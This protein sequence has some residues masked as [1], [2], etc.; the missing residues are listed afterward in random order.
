[1]HGVDFDGC[2]FYYKYKTIGDL[3][4]KNS[5]FL[6]K[7][8]RSGSI[9]FS[10]SARHNVAN[11][12]LN[13]LLYL[14]EGFSSLDF[15]E[16]VKKKYKLTLDQFLF[17]DLFHFKGKEGETWEFIQKIKSNINK[18]VGRYSKV[19]VKKI[20]LSQKVDEAQH[21]ATKIVGKINKKYRLKLDVFST[22][23]FDKMS[24]KRLKQDRDAQ[25]IP[26]TYIAAQ[27]FALRYPNEEVVLNLYDDKLKILHAI[28]DF[29]NPEINH[30]IDLIPKNVT[31]QLWLRKINKEKTLLSS[32]KG[33]GQVDR[34]WKNTV[35]NKEGGESKLKHQY[36]QF[37]YAI[38]CRDELIVWFENFISSE[39]IANGIKSFIIG[40]FYKIFR[41][42][43]DVYNEMLAN[44]NNSS[45][46]VLKSSLLIKVCEYHLEALKAVTQ[47]APAGQSFISRK[48][49]LPL[50]FKQRSWWKSDSTAT[51][52]TLKFK[53]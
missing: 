7:T 14:Q 39:K 31:I 38:K 46:N 10:F 27:R 12:V 43:E 6:G 34:D 8:L 2:V 50:L 42:K 33:T 9:F 19:A 23:G 4:G 24:Y 28:N 3:L 16:S 35:Y 25:K 47:M 53:R 15:Y 52:K 36:N 51:E 17:G 48:P 5:H 21:I 29:Y 30:F 13:R 1:V 40:L 32:F 45:S 49:L 37:F 26:H 44:I 18:V 20:S 22:T 11:E 41:E